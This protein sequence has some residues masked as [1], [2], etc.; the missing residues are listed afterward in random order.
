MSLLRRLKRCRPPW[1]LPV[2][3]ACASDLTRPFAPHPACAAQAAEGVRWALKNRGGAA[4][5]MLASSRYLERLNMLM[6]KPKQAA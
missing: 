3:P 2:V 4:S 5:D 1:P 6:Q